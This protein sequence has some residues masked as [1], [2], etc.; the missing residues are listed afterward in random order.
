LSRRKK[1]GKKEKNGKT[2]FRRVP[3]SINSSFCNDRDLPSWGKKKKGLKKKD[4]QK[5]H[6][7]KLGGA[8]LNPGDVKGV[9]K[10]GK[11][12]KE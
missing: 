4:E 11:K 3:L 10:R 1:K 8:K 6:L 5:F 9:G 2:V 12:T 7:P